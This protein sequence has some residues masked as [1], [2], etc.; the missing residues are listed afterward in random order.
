MASCGIS[1]N[2][3]SIESKI[4]AHI[5]TAIG[6]AGLSGI[7]FLPN[8]IDVAIS[9]SNGN[10][11]GALKIIV[12]SDAFD[13]LWSGLREEFDTAFDFLGPE[14]FQWADGSFADASLFDDSFYGSIKRTVSEWGDDLAGFAKTTGLDQLSGFV[15]IDIADLAK[16]SLGLGASF[17]S[18]DFGVSGI[19]NYFRDPATGTIKLLANYAPKLGDTSVAAGNNV[20]GLALEINNIF[21]SGKANNIFNLNVQLGNVV[22]SGTSYALDKLGSTTDID[23]RDLSNIR[24]YVS[25]LA[26]PSSSLQSVYRTDYGG[27]KLRNTTGQIDKLKGMI[28]GVLSKSEN[29]LGITLSFAT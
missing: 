21:K 17:D 10:I 29:S 1:L 13:G 8:I 9:V 7:P 28:S 5:E 16:S 4:S 25:D 2:L 14:A 20:F 15:D 19:Q 6:F 26:T 24:Q 23:T 22:S 11:L 27:R 12:P 3:S 18:C